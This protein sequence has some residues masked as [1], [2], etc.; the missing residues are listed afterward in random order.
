M[1]KINL[2]LRQLKPNVLEAK[3]TGKEPEWDGVVVTE[4]TRRLQL[5]TSL[6]WYNAHFGNKEAILV[7]GDYLELTKRT[8]DVKKLKKVPSNGISNAYG[9]LARMILKGY[10]ASKVELARIDTVLANAFA[11][12]APAAKDVVTDKPNSPKPNIQDL[13]REKAEEVYAEIDAMLDTYVKDG[14]KGKHS[15]SPIN[16]LKPTSIL[17]HHVNEMIAVW[18]GIRDEFA[19][20][21][22]DEDA[23]LKEGYGHLSKIQLRNLIKFSELVISD[24]NSYL[25]YKK[26]TKAPRKRVVK[27]PEQ[28]TMKLKHMKEFAEL[29]L[30]SVKPAKVVGAKEMYVYSTKKRKLI[31]IVADAHAGNALAVKNNTIVGFDATKTTQKTVRNPANQMKEFMA[32]SKPSSRKVYADTKAVETKFSGRFAD[33]YVILK[34]W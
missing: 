5:A 33:D 14:A 30:T 28:L 19:A 6:S 10:P 29:K 24:S 8:A 27:T 13:M 12:V 31:Y 9:F 2:K 17:P 15:L 26:S 21:Y 18:E 34:V 4:D 7:L 16:V 11:L 23:D 20:A 25:T 1:A 32:A 3:Y 22:A